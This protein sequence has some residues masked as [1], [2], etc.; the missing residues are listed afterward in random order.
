MD[1]DLYDDYKSQS[2]YY[3]MQNQIKEKNNEFEFTF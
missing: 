2:N 3:E 1:N